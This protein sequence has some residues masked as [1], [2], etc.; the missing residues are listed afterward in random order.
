M[1]SLLPN[2]SGRLA[3]LC[4]L[5]YLAPLLLLLQVGPCSGQLDQNRSEDRGT[6]TWGSSTTAGRGVIKSSTERVRGVLSP[7]EEAIEEQ[8]LNMSQLL[9]NFGLDEA[10]TI[11]PALFTFLCPALLYQIDS[12]VCIHHRDEL[13]VTSLEKR[14]SFLWGT[15]KND[16]QKAALKQ[17][18]RYFV[19]FAQTRISALVSDELLVP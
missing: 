5:G 12:R 9:V 19:A 16:G 13:E 3:L 14:V 11:T 2:T 8:C 6:R 10:E 4:M 18:N 15:E 7:V 1:T 17:T